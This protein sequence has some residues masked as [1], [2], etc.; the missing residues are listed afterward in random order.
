MFPN[1]LPRGVYS[2]KNQNSVYIAANLDRHAI[3]V[4][5]SE[6]SIA[7]AYLNL[8]EGEPSI[9]L[10]H[11][12][13][14]SLLEYRHLI[15]LLTAKHK[16]W[17]MDLLGFG[18]TE[19]VSSLT[20]SPQSIREHIYHFWQTLIQRPIIIVGASMGG[21]AAIDFTLNYPEAVSKL[22]LIN[23]VGFNGSFPLGQ[24]LPEA[25][26]ELGTAFWRTRRYGGLF[27]SQNGWLD[28]Y[29]EDA[30]ICA[31]LPSFMPNWSTSLKN[32]TRS[33][34]Y[35]QLES[36]IPL[37]KKPT[38]ILWGEQDDVLG[39]KAATQ[40]QQAIAGSKLIWLP[41]LG[42]SP[43]WQNPQLVAAHLREFINS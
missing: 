3:S 7:T 43:Q 22:V 38:L 39:T 36:Q 20:Y 10:L 4:P 24:I 1:F 2:L 28:A 34:G 12:F 32:F 30:I 27:L 35:Y 14:S 37:V 16:I 42:H 41:G 31:A 15:P 5:F 13:D 8:G 25:I 17:A 21:A 19:R 9:L 26:L 23:S 18:F 33:G 6:Q 29:I 40:F 11:G